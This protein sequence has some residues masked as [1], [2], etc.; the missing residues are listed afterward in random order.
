MQVEALK[1]GGA[2]VAEDNEQRAGLVAVGAGGRRPGCYCSA[3]AGC[4]P[5]LVAASM[6]GA[7]V[8]HAVW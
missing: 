4:P 8:F 1:R 3:M 7:I 6:R 2:V 5:V